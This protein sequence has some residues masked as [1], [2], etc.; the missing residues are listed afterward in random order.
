VPDFSRLVSL[1]PKVKVIEVNE[2][3]DIPV[4]VDGEDLHKI[5]EQGYFVHDE[6]EDDEVSTIRVKATGSKEFIN[7][8]QSGIYSVLFNAGDIR[9]AIVLVDFPVSLPYSTKYSLTSSSGIAFASPYALVIL[10]EGKTDAGYNA[11]IAPRHKVY[12]SAQLLGEAFNNI[13]DKLP[14][15]TNLLSI[16]RVS[17]D[18]VFVIVS[19]YF[20]G[21]EKLT[22][23]F[24]FHILDR[25]K[26]DFDYHRMLVRQAYDFVLD[27]VESAIHSEF[28][29]PERLSA[30]HVASSAFEII[31]GRTRKSIVF[32]HDEHRFYVPH[33]AKYLKLDLSLSSALRDLYYPGDPVEMEIEFKAK[34]KPLKM[35][36]K[37]ADMVEMN[38]QLKDAFTA[39]K[40]LIEKYNLREEDAKKAL[41]ITKLTKQ[42]EFY[43]FDPDLRYVNQE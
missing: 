39:F 37:Q 30:G 14:D 20:A 17:K 9:D 5:L 8:S 26:N 19:K 27:E 28:Q 3:S 31:F 12:A 13:Y 1:E 43:I 6:R 2:L 10:L 34:Y 40:T 16:T 18:D 25:D 29:L 36:W 41:A 32:H 22:S 21:D 33:T 35:I 11:F 23:T 42:A 7:V 15:A 24:P 38:G 4:K